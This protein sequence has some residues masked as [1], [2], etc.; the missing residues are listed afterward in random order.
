[1]STRRN[2]YPRNNQIIRLTEMNRIT[3]TNISTGQNSESGI[4]QKKVEKE[5]NHLVQCYTKNI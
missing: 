1:M 5:R 3:T 4:P 2:T